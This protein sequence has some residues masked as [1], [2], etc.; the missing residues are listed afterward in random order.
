M[1]LTNPL[2]DMKVFRSIVAVIVGYAVF[3]ASAVA[4]F[5]LS[6][7]DP[8]AQQNLG[9]IL[10]SVFYG[11]L[12]AWVGGRLAARIAPARG[13]LHANIVAIIIAFGATVSLVTSPNADATWSQWTAIFLMAPC[14]FLAGV[15]TPARTRTR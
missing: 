6:G 12:F 5:K 4:M 7:R 11:M 10:F 1:A 2:A 9:F 13:P 14:A 3:A 8:H 15:P